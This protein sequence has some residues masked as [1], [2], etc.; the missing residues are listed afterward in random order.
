MSND[1]RSSRLRTAAVTAALL[2][3]PVVVPVAAAGPSCFGDIDFDGEVGIS[4]LLLVLQ[5]WG[6]GS[7]T[8]DFS[9]VDH[10][11][12]GVVDLYDFLGVLEAWG[13]C[14]P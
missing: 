5:D 6:Q 7:G 9:G 4:D 8:S 13:A 12:D 3:L 1:R 11:P 2:A 14:E 10:S